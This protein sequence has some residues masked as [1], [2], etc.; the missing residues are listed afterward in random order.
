MSVLRRHDSESDSELDTDDSEESDDDER[1]ELVDSGVQTEQKETTDSSSG[2]DADESGP[3]M[4][5]DFTMTD[6]VRRPRMGF[7]L[8]VLHS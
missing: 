8:R 2:S 4:T 7:S 5:D 1:P 6:K 3:E